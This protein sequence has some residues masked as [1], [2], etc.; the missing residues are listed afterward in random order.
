MSSVSRFTRLTMTVAIAAALAACGQKP[1]AQGGAM[2]PAEV[3]VVTVAPQR[4]AITNELP[5]RLEAYR[6]AQVRARVAGIVQKRVFKEGSDVKEGQLLFQIDPAQYQASYDNAQANLTQTTLKAQ[7]Y[8]P[9]VEVNAVSKQEYDDAVSAQKQAEAAVRIAKLNL[10]YAS[11]TS[12]ISGRIGRAL[13]TEGAL[14]GQGGDA[15][16]MALVQQLDPI[17]VNVTQSSADL[18]KLQQAMAS[19]QLKSVGDG[20]ASVTLLLENGQ[21]YPL[22]GKLLFS[23]ITVDEATGSISLRAEFPNPKRVL[24]PGTYVRAKIEQAI[25]EQALMVPQQAVMRDLNGSSVFV[26]DADNK[27][28]PRVVKTGS[29]QGNNWQV[30]DGLKEGDRVIVEGL[31]KVRPGAAVKPVQWNPAGAAPNQ[32]GQA[33]Q[34]GAAGAQQKAN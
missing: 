14:V 28:A 6:V 8:K 19:G 24:L 16:Q 34:Q 22:P 32:S 30:I 23:D 21:P 17:Y 13:V 25:D 15:T 31:Q 1:A 33:A 4:I 7:R 2:P 3:S 12:P 5:G 29:A 27:V 20:K 26:V 11:V 9:L 10:G 18:L